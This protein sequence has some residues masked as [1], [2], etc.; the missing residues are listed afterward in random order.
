MKMDH[1]RDAC[2][3]LFSQEESMTREEILQGVKECL[4]SALGIAG[5]EVTLDTPL[6]D[7]DVE[8]IEVLDI[9]FRLDAKFGI[10]TSMT[11]LRARFLGDLKEEEFFDENRVVTEAGLQQL[12]T[13]LPDFDPAK[14]DGELD[15][16]TLFS[17]FTVRHLVELIEEKLGQRAREG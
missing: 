1:R 11:E 3:T 6:T 2:A 4:V 7:L 15:E 13:V 14:F 9:L 8:S 5:D 17:L 16:E 12:K 10:T